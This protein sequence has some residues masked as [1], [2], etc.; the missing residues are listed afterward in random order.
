V[1]T[2]LKKLVP[3]GLATLL[4]LSACSAPT[5]PSSGDPGDPASNQGDSSAGCPDGLADA[6]LEVYHAQVGPYEIAFAEVDPNSAAIPGFA[7]T[8]FDCV[9]EVTYEGDDAASSVLAYVFDPEPSAPDLARI[10][11]QLGEEGFSPAGQ[12]GW[13]SDE[14]GIVTVE[15]AETASSTPEL[16]PIFD[17]FGGTFVRIGYV[18]TGAY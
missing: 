6:E 15:F 3:L 17:S 2:P 9:L 14:G 13:V 8:P 16:A 18:P 10:G 1:I 4:L 12:G 7:D 11:E 5:G